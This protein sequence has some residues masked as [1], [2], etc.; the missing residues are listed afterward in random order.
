MCLRY[1]FVDNCPLPFEWIYYL[2]CTPS[3]QKPHNVNLL[4]YSPSEF[5]PQA[6]RPSFLL[7][8]QLLVNTKKV[9]SHQ[10]IR[11]KLLALNDVDQRLQFYVF[12]TS[13]SLEDHL[14]DDYH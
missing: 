7:S 12:L 10:I 1:K 5:K 13:G 2:S 14:H 8:C 9:A 11:E 3:Y 6:F 4:D